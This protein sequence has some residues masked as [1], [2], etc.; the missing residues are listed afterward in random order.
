MLLKIGI[1]ITLTSLVGSALV[2]V[3]MFIRLLQSK[4][5]RSIGVGESLSVLLTSGLTKNYAELLSESG[6]NPGALDQIV[7]TLHRFL[8][9][10]L[11]AGLLAVILGLI[12]GC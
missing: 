8:G 10:C 1:V 7:S 9:W 2:S 6:K 12:L 4:P 3:I 5:P 11:G